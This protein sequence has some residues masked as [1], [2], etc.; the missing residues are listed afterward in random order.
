MKKIIFIFLF[1]LSQCGYQPIHLNK[2]FSINEFS[3]ISFEGNDEI[4]NKIISSLSFKENNLNDNLE[5]LFVKSSYKIIETK[6]SS[7][8][9]VQSYKS[10]IEFYFLIK[11][12]DKIIKEKNFQKELS[13][14]SKENKFDLV[15]YQNK[16]KNELVNRIIEDI[17][18]YLNI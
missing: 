16:I 14:N 12:Q 11:N 15:Q 13:Y 4:N 2:N 10:K 18:L 9:E 1:L 6:K 17:I 8:G 7:S 3:K 5:K